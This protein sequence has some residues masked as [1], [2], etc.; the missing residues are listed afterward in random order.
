MGSIILLENEMILYSSL[1][2]LGIISFV[3]ASIAD[4]YQRELRAWHVQ[5]FSIA[6]CCVGSGVVHMVLQGLGVWK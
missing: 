6:F 1:I 4:R 2:L 3:V 5:L